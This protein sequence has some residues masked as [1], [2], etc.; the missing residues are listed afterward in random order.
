MSNPLNELR[1]ILATPEK[2]MPEVWEVAGVEA[3]GFVRIE[4]NGKTQ[5]L[6]GGYSIGQSVFVKNSIITGI[7]SAIITNYEV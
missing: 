7:A 3:G 2:Q 1:K 4:R 6:V 5:V